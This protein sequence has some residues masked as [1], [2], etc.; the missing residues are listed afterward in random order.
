MWTRIALSRGNRKEW[1]MA[2]PGPGGAE[3]SFFEALMRG[4]TARLEEVL[5]DDFLLIDVMSGTEVD[6][7]AL[8]A[9][10]GSGDLKFE[11]IEPEGARDRRY[12][13]CAVITG[14][15]RMRGSY[16]GSAFELRSAYTHVMVEQRGVWRMASA[17]GTPLRG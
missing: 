17:Q 14:R 6:R 15:T 12:G 5:T 11:S 2:Q 16:A 9:L 13:T 3:R 8:C 7:A 1:T 4:D 10:V